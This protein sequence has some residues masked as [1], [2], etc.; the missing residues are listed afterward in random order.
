MYRREYCT[1]LHYTY[2]MYSCKQQE[3]QTCVY[4]FPEIFSSALDDQIRQVR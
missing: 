2:G 1:S 4:R 3:S